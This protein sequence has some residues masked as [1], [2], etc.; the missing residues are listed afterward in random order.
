MTASNQFLHEVSLAHHAF[1]IQFKPKTQYAI[2]AT[3]VGIKLFYFQS[4]EKKNLILNSHMQSLSFYHAWQ[5]QISLPGI[6]QLNN[7][8][9]RV[10]TYK[11]CIYI[12]IYKIPPIFHYVTKHFNKIEKKGKCK[13]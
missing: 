11:I 8:Q 10:L 5:K 13:S 12:Y 1:L 7:F 9:F 6:S 4:R 2:I 3:L